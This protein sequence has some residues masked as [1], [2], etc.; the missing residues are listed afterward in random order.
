M[1]KAIK[2]EDSAL[3]L[4][5]IDEGLLHLKK[6]NI[7]SC[8]L[9]FKGSLEM[10]LQTNMLAGD[11][12]QVMQ[13]INSFQQRLSSSRTFLALYGPV[14]FH[15]NAIRTSLDFV[16]Q[17]IQINEEELKQ[18]VS[19]PGHPDSPARKKDVY[20]QVPDRTHTHSAAARDDLVQAAK[21]LLDKG[22]YGKA[23]ELLGEDEESSSL[24]LQIANN[25]GIQYRKAGQLDKAIAEYRKALVLYADDEGLYY[26][27]ARAYLEKKAWAEAE[28]AMRQGMAINPEF[29]AGKDLLIYITKLGNLQNK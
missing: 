9:C 10:T 13:A 25:L 27:I 29:K 6:K 3:I 16:E 8:L 1:S 18:Q 15:D 22:E 2:R 26:N 4:K 21:I 12:K 5:K 7:Y 24:L 11:E 20:V 23:K 28:E 14:T 19:Q 17:L